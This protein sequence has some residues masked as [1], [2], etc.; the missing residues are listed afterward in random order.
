MIDIKNLIFDYPGRR[1]LNDISITVESGQIAALVGPN[2]AGKTTLLRCIAALHFPLSGKIT[3]DGL[4]VAEHPRECH[5]KLGFLSDFFGLY[6]VLSVKQNLSYI[7]MANGIRGEALALAVD[8]AAERLHISDRMAEPVGNLSRGLRQ[9]VA[10]AQAIVHEPQVLLLD[11]PASGLDPEARKSLSNLFLELK[12][13]GMTLMVSSH[14]L[15]ELEDYCTSMIIVRNGVIVD[16]DNKNESAGV[17]CHINISL[18]KKT[19]NLSHKLQSIKEI[20]IIK[21]DELSAQIEMSVSS[22]SQQRVL[23]Q[24]I[25]LGIPVCSFYQVKQQMQDTYLK[26]ISNFDNKL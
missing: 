11:E 7:A 21:T 18:S 5:R 9:R 20:S 25:Q 3:I 22:E 17:T 19:D 23:H 6:K 12:E 26:Q 16:S 24:L 4:D 1:A 14:I 2:G 8:R 10:I 13:Q 15:A